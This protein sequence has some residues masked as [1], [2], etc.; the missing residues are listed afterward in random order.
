MGSLSITA[1]PAVTSGEACTQ[2]PHS[3]V[4]LPAFLMSYSKIQKGEQGELPFEDKLQYDG[5][6]KE[7]EINR[8]N[9]PKGVI[10]SANKNMKKTNQGK[11][12][13]SF[14]YLD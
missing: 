2:N 12:N 10:N 14:R 13:F 1:C 9:N 7:T 6:M 11:I 3:Q 8:K 4:K 5:E